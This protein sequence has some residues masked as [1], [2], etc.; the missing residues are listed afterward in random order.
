[1][2]RAFALHAANP[3]SIPS[4]PY[5]PLSTARGDS[6][7]HEPGVIPVHHRVWP[8]KRKKK[9]KRKQQ[10]ESSGQGA[11][12]ACYLP[13]FNPLSSSNSFLFFLFGSHPAMLRGYCWLCTQELVLVVFGV[14]YGMLGIEP[15]LAACKA[16]AL[17]TVL[18]LQSLSFNSL[19]QWIISQITHS[20]IGHSLF[21]HMW[22]D[23]ENK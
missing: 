8:K 10:R 4:I 15:G 13:G 1:M 5:G 20:S 23:P 2:G 16:S 22:V 9:E 11:S 21:T 7:V 19:E 14:P 18:S 17:P 12:L 6:W 3:G